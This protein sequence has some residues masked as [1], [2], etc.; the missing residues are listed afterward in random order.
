[1][2]CIII[3]YARSAMKEQLVKVPAKTGCYGCWYDSHED[4]QCPL[5]DN[6]VLECEAD[7]MYSMIF[8]DEK[9]DDTN[10]RN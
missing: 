7:D 10:E 2:R 6:G 8:V 9:E 3:S 5:C 1:M 4:V